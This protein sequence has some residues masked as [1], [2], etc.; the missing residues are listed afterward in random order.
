[1]EGLNTQQTPELDVV[2][3]NEKLESAGAIIK[4]LFESVG[5]NA[6]KRLVENPTYENLSNRN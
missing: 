4:T 6:I 1:M 3:R 2:R 5:D